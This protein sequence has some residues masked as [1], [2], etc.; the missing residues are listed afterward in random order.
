MKAHKLG[1]WMD[2]MNAHL[3]EFSDSHE[4]KTV[5]SK[6]T[7]EAKE[8]SLGQGENKMHTKE[9]HQQAEYYKSL[10]EIIKNYK[11]VV[12]FGPTDAKVELKNLLKKEHGFAAIKIVTEQADK[13]TD[14]QEHAFV[15]SY[16]IKH[17]TAL[18]L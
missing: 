8:H 11:E 12:L 18:K 10:G 4:T 7:H 14:N 2:H 17:P 5:H 1:I 16:F 15:H 9:Q 6:F 3:I 13:M